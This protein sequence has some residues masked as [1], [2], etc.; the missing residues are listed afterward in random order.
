MNFS[1]Y[2]FLEPFRL[3]NTSV[4]VI[5]KSAKIFAIFSTSFFECYSYF[6]ISYSIIIIE[7]RN[8]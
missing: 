1:H 6:I 8:F 5:L 2:L 3:I 7:L 4:N